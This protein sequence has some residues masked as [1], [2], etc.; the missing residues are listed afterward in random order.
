MRSAAL[1]RSL[2]GLLALTL[3]LGCRRAPSGPGPRRDVTIF[4]AASLREAF[5]LLGQRLEQTRPGAH[6]VL[7]FAGSQA[8]RAQIEHGAPADVFASA[9]QRHMQALV[10]AGRVLE[11]RVFAKNELCVVVSRAKA[12]EL[13]ELA[14]LP[15]AE[16]VVLGAPEVPVGAYTGQML[17]RA[18]QVLGADFRA[19]VE[20][21]VVSREPD[22]R[23]VL[24][25][26]TL[27]E[28]DAGVVYLTDALT[29]KDKLEVL[30]IPPAFNVV[31]EYPLAVTAGAPSP[32]LAR[33]FVELVL[34]PE[35][36]SALAKQGFLPVGAAPP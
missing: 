15:R 13:T 10:A 35:G 25:K 21:R 29:Q 28:A 4:A 20:A 5:T 12:R 2:L 34:S 32:E 19:R 7:S 3:V 26:V 33:A 1:R 23:Q 8:L 6:V 31:A 22:V 24:A 11:P 14:A 17:D 27:G 16:R 9:D 30:P 18:S 36:Q